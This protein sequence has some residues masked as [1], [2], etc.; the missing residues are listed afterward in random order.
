LGK[1]CQKQGV[2]YKDDQL[3]NSSIQQSIKHIRTA[4]SLR[5]A[6]AHLAEAGPGA[7]T[8]QL[9]WFPSLTLLSAL[10]LLGVAYADN[11]ARAGFDIAVLIFWVG[12]LTIFAPIALRLCSAASARVERMGLVGLLGLGLYLI[13][14]M[15]SPLAF[16]Y[17]DEAAH[18]RATLDI[19]RSGHLFMP[20]PHLLVGPFYPGL[21]NVTTAIVSM[22]GLSVFS[23]GTLILGVGRIV[24]VLTL[25]FFFER[26]S[27]SDHVAGVAALLYMTNSHFLFFDAQYSYESLALT[28]AALVLFYAARRANTQGSARV[29]WNFLMVL[30]FAIVIVT[31]HVTSYMLVMFVLAWMMIARLSRQPDGAS[32]NTS[33]LLVVVAT[34]TWTAYVAFLTIGYLAP[35]ISA[36]VIELGRLISGEKVGRELFLS[37]AGQTVP[38]WERVIGFGTIGLL[39]GGMPFG[40]LRIWRHYRRN[41][42]A[43][44]LAAGSLA[45]P[46]TLGLRLTHRGFEISIR[47]TEFVFVGLAFVL[48]LG[49]VALLRVRRGAR[50]AQGLV[51]LYAA[52]LFVGGVV[53]GRPIWM[54]LPGAY[55][56]AADTRSIEPQGVAAAEWARDTLG[57]DNHIATDRVNRLLMGTV[58]E[59]FPITSAS[60][61]VPVHQ[62][63]FAR[64]ISPIERAILRKGQIRYLVVDRRLSTALPQVGFYFEQGEPGTFQRTEPLAPELLAKF[65]QLPRT[66]RVFDSGDIIIYDVRALSGEH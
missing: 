60:S 40:L 7:L 18:W 49:L 4:T 30:G 54:R 43:L 62:V 25:F 5:P 64:Q 45:Y 63:F 33:A 44:T 66:N 24:L 35:N 3:R 56:V 52:T 36:G 51:L 28:F 48:A 42:L 55:L 53:V 27:Q 11:S 47:T 6:R 12:M 34:L 57:P 19:L 15:N 13:K 20:N 39:L 23:A 32:G 65:D 59:Q 10:G 61:H 8:L 26:I 58:G 14:V 31:H 16:T 50:L 1:S 38:L 22:S 37:F 29:G 9:G 17:H 21:E 46:A 2:R 41:T